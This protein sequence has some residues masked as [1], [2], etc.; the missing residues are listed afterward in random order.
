VD[1][2]EARNPALY[3]YVTVVQNLKITDIRENMI[4]QYLFILI[5]NLLIFISTAQIVQSQNNDLKLYKLDYYVDSCGDPRLSSTLYIQHRGK[6]I[7]INDKGIFKCNLNINT[8]DSL[9][10]RTC[11]ITLAGV[12]LD[13]N[14]LETIEK[15]RKLLIG[16]EI[17]VN[18]AQY[19]SITDTHFEGLIYYDDYFLNYSLLRNGL[20]NFR[21]EPYTLDFWTECKFKEAVRVDL[22][23]KEAD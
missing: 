1:S 20:T 21:Y 13:R 15:L 8:N 14:N 3:I 11:Y 18:S 16:K 2:F 22:N 5:I 7:D 4:K 9:N 19:Q 6:L 17:K 12:D 10:F 23:I